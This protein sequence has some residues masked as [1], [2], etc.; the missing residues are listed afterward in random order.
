MKILVAG[1]RGQVARALLEAAP[2]HTCVLLQCI[3]RPDLDL[4]KPETIARA[5]AAFVPDLVIN[6]AAYTDVDRAEGDPAT[7]FSV[8]RDG[9]GAVAAAAA[10]GGKPI[11]HLS[12]DY[13][14]D[15]AT[16]GAYLESDEPSPRSV[17]GRSKLEGEHAVAEANSRHIILR[18]AWIYAPFGSNFV[19][20]VLRLANE[21]DHLAIVDD[22]IGCPTYAPDIAEAILTIAD[23]LETTG[24]RPSYAG[25]THLA[26]PEAMTWCAFARR[27]FQASAARGGRA[28]QIDPITSAEYPTA[29]PRPANSW[30]ASDRL[31]ALFGVRLPRFDESV[32]DCLD[33]LFAKASMLEASL[34]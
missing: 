9:A 19:R 24:W 11:I 32:A 12:S 6:A 26:G 27:V 28:V 30:L 7:A 29:A 33:R 4:L 22:Q 13:V 23:R 5:V 31:E 21:R 2:N 14:F 18:T 1:A 3:G 15:G 20:T 8:N 10:L 34:D 16:T 17:Y 25:V